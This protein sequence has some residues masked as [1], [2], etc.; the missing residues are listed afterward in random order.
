MKVGEGGEREW[1][2]GREGGNEG[3]WGGVRLNQLNLFC[4]IH[5]NDSSSVS[6]CRTR[7]AAESDLALN[8]GPLLFKFGNCHQASN[9][10]TG[11]DSVATPASL[12]VSTSV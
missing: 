8:Q 10:K 7:N 3:V 4:L 9:F 2:G 11:A 1:E 6:N 12:C 5:V